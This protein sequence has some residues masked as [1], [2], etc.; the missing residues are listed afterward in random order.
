MTRRRESDRNKTFTQI[1][2]KR[3]R[4]D[5]ENSFFAFYLFHFRF[6]FSFTFCLSRVRFAVSNRFAG[7]FFFLFGALLVVGKWNVAF[8]RCDLLEWKTVERS[9]KKKTE[10]CECETVHF[11]GYFT[12]WTSVVLATEK[13]SRMMRRRERFSESTRKTNLFAQTSARWDSIELYFIDF[14][15]EIWTNSDWRLFK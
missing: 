6:A 5:E 15:D 10:N 11:Y 12:R 2:P 7:N 4:V 14:A 13:T 8:H 9:K 1:Q 3:K